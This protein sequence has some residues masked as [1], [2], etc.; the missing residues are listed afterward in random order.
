[1]KSTRRPKRNL[2]LQI[3]LHDPHAVSTREAHAYCRRYS[4]GQQAGVH[5]MLFAACDKHRYR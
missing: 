2:Q 1:V 3:P 4:K 5:Y